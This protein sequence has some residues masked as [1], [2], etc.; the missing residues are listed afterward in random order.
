ML[1]GL[2]MGRFD[3]SKQRPYPP[4]LPV[5]R[6]GPQRLEAV[7]RTIG[8]TQLIFGDDALTESER[9]IWNTA[10]LLSIFTEILPDSF[11]RDAKVRSWPAARSGLIA[12]GLPDAAEHVASLVKELAYRAEQPRR[13]R[14]DDGASL[15]R[16]AKLK[17]GF[18][19]IE[20][21]HDLPTMLD[22]MAEQLYPW[23]D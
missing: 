23:T 10:L 16:L 19:K 1:I 13:S 9:I 4:R 7:L 14:D 11:W 15:E 8:Q 2:I 12:M 21:E 5:S 17:L 18:R 6:Y 20:T 22:E 3:R